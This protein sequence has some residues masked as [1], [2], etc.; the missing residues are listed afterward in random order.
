MLF[1]SSKKMK[2]FLSITF[3][4]FKCLLFKK[5]VCLCFDK[6]VLKM[7]VWY[8]NV[9]EFGLKYFELVFAWMSRRK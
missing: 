7:L 4:L 2:T 5:N 3:S 6:V 8:I 1:S 9:I